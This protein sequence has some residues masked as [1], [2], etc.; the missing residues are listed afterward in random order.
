MFCRYCG[1][2]VE[3][4]A[5]FCGMCGNAIDRDLKEFNTCVSPVNNNSVV[6]ED[7]SMDKVFYFIHQ[8]L[9]SKLYFNLMTIIAVAGLVIAFKTN[10]EGFTEFLEGI[11]IDIEGEDISGNATTFATSTSKETSFSSGA[12]AFVGSWSNGNGK[13]ECEITDDGDGT[14][15]MHSFERRGASE[16]AEGEYYGVYGSSNG[17]MQFTGILRVGVFSDDD[18]VADVTRQVDVIILKMGSSGSLQREYNGVWEDWL[19]KYN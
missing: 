7:T 11:G 4:E 15:T 8:M 2:Q 3:T 16:F 12:A 1:T 18:G 13:Y 9:S 6:A 17:T 10:P 14:F 5:K 19:I